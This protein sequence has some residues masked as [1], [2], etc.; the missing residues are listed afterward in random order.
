MDIST[1]VLVLLPSLLA[2][3][4][5]DGRYYLTQ[6]FIEGVYQFQ[7]YWPGQVL[8]LM[9]SSPEPDVNLDSVPL[10]TLTDVNIKLCKY[11][12]LKGHLEA[13]PRPAVALSST[14]CQQ[15]AVSSICRDTGVLC[16]PTTEYSLKTRH[17][18]VKAERKSILRRLYGY[19]WEYQQER[20]NLASL[21]GADSVQCNGTPTY[22]AY[23]D[24]HPNP[25]L[26]LDNRISEK[27]LANDETIDARLKYCLAGDPLRLAFS[28]R[29]DK[30]K[31]V[32]HL[33]LIA[34]FLKK[35]GVPFKLTIYGDGE[36][37]SE[38]EKQILAK[39]LGDSVIL[40][41]VLDF[42]TRLV[43][44]VTNN[45]DLFLCCHLQGDPSCTYIETMSC[46]VPIVGYDNEAF[47]GIHDLSGAGWLVPM[48]RV[49]EMGRQIQHLHLRREE[50]ATHSKKSKEFAKEYTFEKMF[51]GR[52]DHLLSVLD[53]DKNEI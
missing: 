37:K 7:K 31:G 33:P 8:V 4:H 18:I 22:D 2:C 15:N 24:L 53:K 9:E 40:G 5:D 38:I 28:G 49:E 23:K 21:I 26:F 35:E 48:N 16:V 20:Q 13:L 46:G 50:I 19:Y 51:K 3:K 47:S 10:D 30:M 42:Q 44:E 39:N 32:N 27:D 14:V 52:I 41:G 36:L 34:E 6:K 1:P 11:S 29:L 17:Q 25:L 45:V 43:P 12:D